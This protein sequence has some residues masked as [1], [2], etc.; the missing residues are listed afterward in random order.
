MVFV[1]YALKDSRLMHSAVRKDDLVFQIIW[2]ESV[3]EYRLY[4]LKANIDN[5][6]RHSECTIISETTFDHNL[7][8]R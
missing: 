7:K 5:P 1:E 4:T 6:M 3:K 8:P 2:D